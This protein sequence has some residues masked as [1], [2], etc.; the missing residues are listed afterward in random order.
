MEAGALP[1]CGIRAVSLEEV[2][3]QSCVSQEEK[4][5]SGI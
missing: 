5:G 3:H 2:R 4:V 1:V